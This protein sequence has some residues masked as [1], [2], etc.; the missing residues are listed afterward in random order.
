M[1]GIRETAQQEYIETDI[2]ISDS[3]GCLW[4]DPSV[5]HAAELMRRVYERQDEAAAVGA[6]AKASL[7]DLLSM[8]AY[9]KR[10]IARLTASSAS[11]AG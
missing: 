6:R 11:P 7:E 4:A 2:N 3:D 10:M 1:R 9:G 8:D 5:P